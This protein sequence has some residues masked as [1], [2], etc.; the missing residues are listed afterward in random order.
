MAALKIKSDIVALDQVDHTG[1]E[2]VAIDSDEELE[3]GIVRNG[4]E[5]PGVLGTCQDALCHQPSSLLLHERRSPHLQPSF[6]LYPGNSSSILEALKIS[7]ITRGKAS[8]EVVVVLNL[9]VVISGF[10]GVQLNQFIRLACLSCGQSRPV[11]KS[12]H[13]LCYE[14]RYHLLDRVVQ[15]ARAFLCSD[16]QRQ[17]RPIPID[18]DATFTLLKCQS[19]WYISRHWEAAKG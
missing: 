15:M 5:I 14:L 11:Q 7:T 8:D 16:S 3:L 2:A 13:T 17:A 18:I 9:K 4:L 1:I 19:W 6:A 12:G 10:R